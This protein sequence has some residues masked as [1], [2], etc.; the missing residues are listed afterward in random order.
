VS[1]AISSA[2]TVPQTNRILL[3][4][5]HE[6]ARQPTTKT[7]PKVDFTL[8]K[9]VT[10]LASL[11]PSITSGYPKKVYN[12]RYL[13]SMQILFLVQSNMSD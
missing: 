10:Q 2:F 8:S 4:D 1:R 11:Y 13:S 7:N 5:F 9:S 6:T 3:H 12:P